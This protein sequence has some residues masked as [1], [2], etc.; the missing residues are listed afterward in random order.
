MIRLET[1][2]SV[3][4]DLPKGLLM[5]VF[6]LIMPSIDPSFALRCSAS[7]GS[8]WLPEPWQSRAFPGAVCAL[9]L[10]FRLF[11]FCPS[12]LVSSFSGDFSSLVPGRSL[13][14]P[15]RAAFCTHGISPV[16]LDPSYCSSALSSYLLFSSAP[17]LP[18]CLRRLVLAFAVAGAP[19]V[20]SSELRCSRLRVDSR[21]FATPRTLRCCPCPVARVLPTLA[22]SSATRQLGLQRPLVARSR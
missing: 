3:R 13:L 16:P 8:V 14:A 17:G 11:W 18:V 4:K 15:L 1:L 20:F 2:F 12:L 10:V 22:L 19:L 5:E 21:A 9:S 6:S 7:H